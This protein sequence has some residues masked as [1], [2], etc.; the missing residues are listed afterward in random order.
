MDGVSVESKAGAAAVAAVRVAAPAQETADAAAA[1]AAAAAA[2]RVAADKVAAMQ[3]HNDSRGSSS[4]SSSPEDRYPRRHCRSKSAGSR[5]G[6]KENRTFVIGR[7]DHKAWYDTLVPYLRG[8]HTEV[9]H[10]GGAAEEKQKA[11]ILRF[12]ES[13]CKDEVLK[14]EEGAT[15]S[16]VP[17]YDSDN[18]LSIR[19][20]KWP[21]QSI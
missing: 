6:S 11:N 14:W 8:P 5:V 1:A 4:D 15:R 20:S 7:S 13:Q 18:D 16:L 12:V 17:W 10:N 19:E 2:T 3:R 9:A 21:K